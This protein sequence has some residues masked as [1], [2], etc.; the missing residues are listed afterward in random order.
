MS[1][2]GMHVRMSFSFLTRT[3][4]PAAAAT[5]AIPTRFADIFLVVLHGLWRWLEPFQ[6]L[7]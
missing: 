6:A 2:L 3:H 5:A 7:E 4:A 1:R